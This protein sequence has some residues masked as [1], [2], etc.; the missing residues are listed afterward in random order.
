MIKSATLLSAALLASTVSSAP[1]DNVERILGVHYANNVKFSSR[2]SAH[3]VTDS[4]AT[5][6][7]Q[8]TYYGGPVISNVE[9]NMLLWGDHVTS[10]DKLPGFYSSVTSSAHY[11]MLSQYK[12][13]SQTIGRGSFKESV[14]L[15]G[16]P[17]KSSIT[18]ESDIKPYLRS[19]V[20]AGTIKPNANTYYP[21]HFAPGIKISMQGQGSCSVF[22]AYHGTIDISDISSTKYLYYGV[23]PDQGGNC[24]RG[25]GSAADPFA[26]LCSVASHEL[27]EATTDPA[28]GVATR[29]GF[30]LGWYNQQ[31]GE[32]GDLCNANQG[33]IDGYT[34]QKEWSNSAGKCV[35]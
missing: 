2:S 31:N 30:P 18:D 17:A 28:V 24:A 25:C 20:K 21:I 15:S 11:D 3:V 5:T 16:F 4:V 26:N 33:T 32:I 9:V 14:T 1:T 22:C 19:L 7:Q 23:I 12:T 27:V 6:A 8:L 35:V 34:I 10:S 29:I 13:P